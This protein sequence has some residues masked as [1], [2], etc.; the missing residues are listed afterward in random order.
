MNIRREIRRTDPPTCNYSAAQHLEHLAGSG[1]TQLLLLS[2]QGGSLHLA[3]SQ[4]PGI[5]GALGAVSLPSL[6]PTITV[7]WRN[8]PWEKFQQNSNVPRNVRPQQNPEILLTL[9]LSDEKQFSDQK[10]FSD[11]S[12]QLIFTVRMSAW[13][14]QCDPLLERQHHTLPSGAGMLPSPLTTYRLGDCNSVHL[15]LKLGVR[16]NLQP[17]CS[18][19][20]LCSWAKMIQL[21]HSLSSKLS[22]CEFKV[23]VSVFKVAKGAWKSPLLL[24]VRTLI[25]N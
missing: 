13:L 22:G 20:F 5:P 10:W 18:E 21:L 2:R 1:E 19:Y 14:L 17:A 7:K 4:P 15:P 24:A 16:M 6:I 12:I 25:C 23:M 8:L 9:A 3:L 11:E